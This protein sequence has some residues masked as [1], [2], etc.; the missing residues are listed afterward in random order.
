MDA[1]LLTI[2]NNKLGKYAN[3]TKKITNNQR[4]K[5]NNYVTVQVIDSK[6][7]IKILNPDHRHLTVA[8][9]FDFTTSV[10]EYPKDNLDTREKQIN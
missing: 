8:L 3:F 1:I 7:T 6:R 2:M 5:E 4:L 10:I 9:N